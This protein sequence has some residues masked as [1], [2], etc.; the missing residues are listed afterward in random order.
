MC[1]IINHPIINRREF[2]I[3]HG[4]I[5]VFAACDNS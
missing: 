3:R 2:N 4:V 1:E 5:G